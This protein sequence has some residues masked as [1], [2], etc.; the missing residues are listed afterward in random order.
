MPTT[1]QVVRSLV[2]H[3][4]NAQCAWND[5]I[6]RQPCAVTPDKET[7]LWKPQSPIIYLWTADEAGEEE[8]Y[9]VTYNGSVYMSPKFVGWGSQGYRC[10]REAPP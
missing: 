10:V 5:Q 9:Y 2:R 8:A 4:E 6:G 7:P 3:G 1:D